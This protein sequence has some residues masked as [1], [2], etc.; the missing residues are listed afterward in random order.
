M[1]IFLLRY[2]KHSSKHREWGTIY[3]CNFS[4]NS[5]HFGGYVFVKWKSEK[6]KYLNFLI[7]GYLRSQCIYLFLTKNKLLFY[8]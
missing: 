5:K 2:R 1:K 3:V 7:F 6:E 4:A 8:F